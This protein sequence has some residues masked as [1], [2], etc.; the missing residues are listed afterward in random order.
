MQKY[1]VLCRIY[2]TR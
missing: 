2:L 1:D